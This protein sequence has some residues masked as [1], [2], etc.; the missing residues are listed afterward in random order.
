MGY[1]VPTIEAYKAFFTR[2]GLLADD[3]G[4]LWAS[5]NNKSPSN[6]FWQA[7]QTV[8]DKWLKIANVK[9]PGL[10]VILTID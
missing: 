9:E 5:I 10:H 3:A 2:D 4:Q 7:Q 1:N 6:M 8:S